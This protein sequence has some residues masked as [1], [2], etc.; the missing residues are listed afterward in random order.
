MRTAPIAADRIP[1]SGRNGATPTAAIPLRSNPIPPT[2]VSI[3]IIVTPRGLSFVVACAVLDQILH[4][5]LEYIQ[6]ANFFY[7]VNQLM[8]KL[9]DTKCNFNYSQKDDLLELQSLFVLFHLFFLL[10]FQ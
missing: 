1:R 5:Y 3:A 9:S 7:N 10:P 2:T 8:L 6:L 4:P